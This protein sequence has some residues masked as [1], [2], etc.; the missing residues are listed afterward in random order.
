MASAISCFPHHLARD[1][2]PYSGTWL[3]TLYLLHRE[4]FA[5]GVINNAKGWEG[6]KDTCKNRKVFSGLK[7]ALGG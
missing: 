3:F 2:K 7:W 4:L 1:Q 6:I 5:R